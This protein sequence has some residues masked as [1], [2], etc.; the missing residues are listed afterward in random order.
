[1]F[2]E[3]VER[4]LTEGDKKVFDKETGYNSSKD[5]LYIFDKLKERY[6]DVIMSY[7]D[8][9]FVNPDT[10]RP[11]QADFYIPSKDLF[12]NYMKIFTHGRRK[13]DP[14]N[15]EHEDDVK[16]LKSKKGEF[17]KR[18]LKQWTVTDPIKRQVANEQGF[19][20]IEFFNLDEFE[21]WFANPSLTYDEYMQPTSLQYDSDEYFQQKARGRDTNGSDSDPYAP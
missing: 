4:V 15:P 6:P 20:L 11:F 13:Y 14:T 17:Y 2:K 1:M 21:A 5:E 19:T 12:I 7:T 16:W 9:R 10:H 3:I 18:A 8:E